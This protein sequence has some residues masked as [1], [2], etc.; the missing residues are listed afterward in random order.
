MQRELAFH[1]ACAVSICQAIDL[2]EAL[3]LLRQHGANAK[4]LAGG[5][6]LMP[7]LDFGMLRPAVL[8][9]INRIP[10]LGYITPIE[11]HGVCIGCLTRHYSLETSPA[12]KARFPI[13]QAAT[14]HVAHLAIRNR[15]T[16]GGSLAMRIRPPNCR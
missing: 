13:L 10:G 5:Q 6:S 16:F 14:T 15:G 7:L 12:I 9:D 8:I 11:D 3:S 2:E 4:I 1:E